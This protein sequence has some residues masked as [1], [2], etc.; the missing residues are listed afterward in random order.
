MALVMSWT[1][2]S[3]PSPACRVCFSSGDAAKLLARIYQN[4][5]M[6]YLT[7]NSSSIRS[8]KIK[9]NTSLPRELAEFCR[10]IQPL[11]G[12]ISFL[13]NRQK[14]T[15]RRAQLFHAHLWIIRTWDLSTDYSQCPQQLSKSDLC[16]KPRGR[17]KR[18]SAADA[19]PSL[20]L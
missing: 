15:A 6:C 10:N 16:L 2:K 14:P 13:I 9:I 17:T 7:W 11:P 8:K 12:G 5:Q 4:E 3:I 18:G 19:A 20:G 1:Q